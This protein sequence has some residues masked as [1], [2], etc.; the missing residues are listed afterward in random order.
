MVRSN[1]SEPVLID[2]S[3][4]GGGSHGAFTWGVPDRLLKENRLGIAAISGTSAGAMNAAVLAEGSVDGGAY[5]G[6]A[7]AALHFY[8]GDR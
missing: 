3:L 6:R 8:E 5:G 1:K 2:L 4:H 7:N